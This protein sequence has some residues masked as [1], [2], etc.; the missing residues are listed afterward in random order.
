MRDYDKLYRV[1][2]TPGE[3]TANIVCLGLHRRDE[4]GIAGHAVKIESL[5]DWFRRKLDVLVMMPSSS[6]GVPAPDFPSI[7]KRITYS[8]FWIY[9]GEYPGEESKR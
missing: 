1:E 4:G 7:G 5:P 8:S 6:P 9:D 2:Y 3:A